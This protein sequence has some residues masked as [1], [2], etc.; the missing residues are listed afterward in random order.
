MRVLLL[1]L[2]AALLTGTAAAAGADATAELRK[3]TELRLAANLKKDRAFYERLLAPNFVLLRP[4]APGQTRADYL[5]E[6][7]PVGAPPAGL[8]QEL[9]RISDFNAFVDGDTAV[10]TYAVVEALNVGGVRFESRQMRVDTYARVGGT[11]RLL[12]MA[13]TKPPT[14]PDIA[15]VSPK[16]YDAY[17]GSY[18]LGKHI[19]TVTHERGHLMI[20]VAGQ[21][22]V[23][24]FPE[25]E[26]TFFDK[27]DAS[28]A[29]T[30]FERDTSGKVVASVYRAEGQ[31]LRYK[32]M[33]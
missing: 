16:L 18:A 26:T 28:T 3:L 11:W 20:S 29:R 27:T 32:R 12:S 13:V 33:P 2:V 30:V 17:A 4:E 8:K 6:E 25:N 24:L 23:E 21:G 1:L 7:F 15:N 31:K 10:A 19:V 9:G 14:W 22:K 5:K